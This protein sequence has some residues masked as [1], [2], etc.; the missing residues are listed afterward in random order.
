MWA[1]PIRYEQSSYYKIGTGHTYCEDYALTE[2]IKSVDIRLP[3]T[4]I[5]L[6]SDGCSGMPDTDVGSRLITYEARKRLHTV[7]ATQKFQPT[8]FRRKVE[9]SAKATASRIGVPWTVLG[10]TLLG[11][12]VLG[13]TAYI[14]VYGDGYWFH[15]KRDGSLTIAEIEYSDNSPA[16]PVYSN[17]Q[18]A[19]FEQKHGGMAHVTTR[20]HDLYDDYEQIFEDTQVRQFVHRFPIED[21]LEFGVGTDGFGSF[22]NAF[23]I[24][25]IDMIRAVVE[26]P[27]HHSGEIGV[28]VVGA[29]N[30]KPV[31][32][33]RDDLGIAVIR[34]EH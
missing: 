10:A 24:D 31:M 26:H 12:F 5:A 7:I 33:H 9:Q 1:M 22:A 3:G 28:Q 21:T 32:Y 15:R 29:L 2:H 4:P 19:V 25:G 17:E 8:R 34:V 30:R 16:Y 11:G 14:I 20:V 18:Y 13:E 6:V 27:R 23:G